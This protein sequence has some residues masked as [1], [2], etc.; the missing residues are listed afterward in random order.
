MLPQMVIVDNHRY[1]HRQSV[2]ILLIYL[3]INYDDNIE[4][5][6]TDESLFKG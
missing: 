6:I 3:L 2:I 1:Y 4:K 5:N